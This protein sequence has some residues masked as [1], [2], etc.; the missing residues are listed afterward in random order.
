MKRLIVAA[1]AAAVAAT[2]A[3][4]ALGGAPPTKEPGKLIVGINPPAPGFT[5]GK[6]NSDNSVSNPRGFEIDLANAIAKRL[7]LE[8]EYVNS[9]FTGL[10]RPGP[11]PFDFAFEQITITAERAK[12]VD[13]S[14]PYFDANQG[15][16]VAKGVKPPRTRAEL[17]QLQTCSQATTTGLDWIKTKLRPT[18]PPLVYQT[19]AAAFQ[20][21]A[22]GKCE[23]IIM[24]VPISASEKRTHP[25]KYGPLV[26]QIV[27]NEKYGALLEQGNPFKATLNAQIKALTADGTLARL[28]K[29]WFSPY[30]NIPVIR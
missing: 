24:D 15:V 2:I 26:G 5:V 20:A 10:F 13:F 23:A 22:I 11:K 30:P 6:I 28:Q 19:L 9:P 14:T 25:A 7:G 18:K 1:L 29:K 17:K 4:T 16:L 27:T 8:V 21:V 12:V 3:A